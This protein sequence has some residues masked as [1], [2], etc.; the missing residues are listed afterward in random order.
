MSVY[1]CRNCSN[2]KTRTISKIDLKHLSRYKIMNALNCY[3]IESLGLDFPF[4]LTVY[5]RIIK[6][7]ECKIIHCSQYMFS[8]ELYIFRDTLGLD[9]L[10]PKKNK[11]CPKYK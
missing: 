10:A 4:N 5:K 11:P 8:R 6:H 3:D 9:S 2:L 1:T 7:G